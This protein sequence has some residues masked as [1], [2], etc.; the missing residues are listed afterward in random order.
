[1]RRQ[2]AGD[3]TVP[4]PPP[5]VSSNVSFSI[6]AVKPLP[7]GEMLT[8]A[9]G[10]RDSLAGAPAGTSDVRA[11]RTT[12]SRGGGGVTVADKKP[13]R[14]PLNWADSLSTAGRWAGY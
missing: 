9:H 6:S 10:P 2:A 13:D 1:M 5:V 3:I 11:A 8:R 7:R 4:P 12:T 14:A